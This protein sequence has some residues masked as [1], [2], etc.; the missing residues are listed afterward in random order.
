MTPGLTGLPKAEPCGNPPGLIG[1]GASGSLLEL[2]FR[3]Q[4]KRYASIDLGVQLRIY[5]IVSALHPAELDELAIDMG[6]GSG[7]YT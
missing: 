1:A 6:A 3:C 5:G 2:R 4:P 7:V